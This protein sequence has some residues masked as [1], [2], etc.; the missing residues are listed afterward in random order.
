M[1][2]SRTIQR[3]NEL[4]LQVGENVKLASDQPCTGRSEKPA[5]SIATAARAMLSQSRGDHRRALQLLDEVGATADP[6]CQVASAIVRARANTGLGE[7]ELAEVQIR[8]AIGVALTN[9]LSGL[10]IA[11]CTFELAMILAGRQKIKDAV[12]AFSSSERELETLGKAAMPHLVMVQQAFLAFA[13]RIGEYEHATRLLKAHIS[14]ARQVEVDMDGLGVIDG[15][16]L[17]VL[18]S[19]TQWV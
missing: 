18:N 9:H 6:I 13:L 8:Q 10:L 12:D 17:Q 3:I 14:L 4:T 15:A 19:P 16:M 7:L 1:L 2:S 11:R 5:V